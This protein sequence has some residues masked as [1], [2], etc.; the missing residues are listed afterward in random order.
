MRNTDSLACL[1]ILLT[2]SGGTDLGARVRHSQGERLAVRQK[3]AG[4]ISLDADPKSVQFEHMGYEEVGIGNRR[5]IFIDSEGRKYLLR[6]PNA[7][8]I[9]APDED[10]DYVRGIYIGAKTRALLNERGVRDL[11][12][13]VKCEIPEVGQK[14]GRLDVHLV[15]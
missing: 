10:T 2:H 7:D 1:V 3:P 5:W 9:I 6:G 13:I 12:L 14:I 4:D 11:E 8:E 15:P